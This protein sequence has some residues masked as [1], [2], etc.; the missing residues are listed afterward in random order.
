MAAAAIPSTADSS[1]SSSTHVVAMPAWSRWVGLARLA[2]AVIVLIMT[3]T[4]AGLWEFG[5][6]DAAFGLTLFT[7][8]CHFPLVTLLP[9]D[10]VVP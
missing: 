3:A 1:P 5:A 7:V 2:L 10:Q 9:T 4:A 8:R 6:A